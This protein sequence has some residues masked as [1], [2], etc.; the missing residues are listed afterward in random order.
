MNI[1]SQVILSIEDPG[2]KKIFK[3]NNSELIKEKALFSYKS[4]EQLLVN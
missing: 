4:K 2:V 3:D 1:V